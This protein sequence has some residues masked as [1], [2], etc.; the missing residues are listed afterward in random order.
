M[1]HDHH[2]PEDPGAV[3][4]AYLVAARSGDWQRAFAFFAD[5]ITLR[6]P[7]RSRYAGGHRGRKAAVEYIETARRIPTRATS[8]SN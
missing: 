5:D 6:I 1:T 4:R 8:P 7:G 2:R 3:M